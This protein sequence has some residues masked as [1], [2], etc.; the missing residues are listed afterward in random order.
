ML[1]TG[2]VVDIVIWSVAE[3]GSAITLSSVPAIRPLIAH[4]VGGGLT[5]TAKSRS[6]GGTGGASQSAT[7]SAQR[8]HQQLSLKN[9]SG[10]TSQTNSAGAFAPYTE[11]DDIDDGLQKTRR[12][13]DAESQERIFE[14]MAAK[15]VSPAA[16]TKGW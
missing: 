8:H 15:R 4:Y 11:L 9:G 5:T 2:D 12:S 10:L 13:G 6:G 14:H 7:V 16:A 1:S 3:L